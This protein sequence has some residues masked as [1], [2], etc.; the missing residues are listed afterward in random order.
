[1]ASVAQLQKAIDN[2]ELDTSTLNRDQLVALDKAF[3]NGTLKGYPS[4]NAMRIEQGAAADTL[5]KEK[6]EQL[7]HNPMGLRV[8]ERYIDDK[9]NWVE[10]KVF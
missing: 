6:E 1:M 9:G 8:G 3:K 10:Y 4:I 2:K 5:A 7:I